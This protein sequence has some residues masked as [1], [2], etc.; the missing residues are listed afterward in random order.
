MGRNLG[1]GDGEPTNTVTM[2]DLN[3]LETR[4]SSTLGNTIKQLHK[5]LE[6]LVKD[7][8]DS[9][10][11]SPQEVTPSIRKVNSPASP[12]VVEVGDNPNNT[13]SST[14]R[15]GGKGE[16]HES[17]RWYSPDPPIPHPHI[18]N[19]GDPPNLAAS[20]FAQW[21]SLMKSHV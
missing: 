15:D 18:N 9:S 10:S 12:A 20:T 17:Q 7:K 14:K 2:E 11:P 8:G 16:Q 1:E 3:N 19:R 21:Q 5:L 4:L 6:Q 13:N